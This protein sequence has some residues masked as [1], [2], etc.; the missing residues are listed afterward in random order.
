MA[1]RAQRIGEAASQ[2]VPGIGGGWWGA[3]EAGNIRGT[4]G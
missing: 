1:Q 4:W 2:G 3:T